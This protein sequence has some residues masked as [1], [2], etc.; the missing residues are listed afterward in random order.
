METLIWLDDTRDPFDDNKSWLVFSPILDSMY[1]VIW[2]KSYK[3]FTEYIILN[4]LPK[5][6]CFDYDLG[7]DVVIK[8]RSK[9]ISKR[10]SKKLKK[11][12]L[13]GGDCAKW[14]IKYCIDNK[15]ELPLYNIQSAN[16]EGKSEIIKILKQN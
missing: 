6:I 8:A 2:L 11:N 3:E 15:K 7:M 9:G 12:E 14:L 16:S 1:K 4:G 10:A 5:G 13:N